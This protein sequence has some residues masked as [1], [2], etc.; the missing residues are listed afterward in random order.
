MKNLSKFYGR[1]GYQ[2]FVDR[3]YRSENYSARPID[4]RI[5]RDWNNSTVIWEP[6][7]DGIFR[8]REFYGGNLRGI[9]E[10]LD[11]L[12]ELGINLIIL[13]PISKTASNHHYD[14]EDQRKID[15]YI[16]TATDFEELC[17]KAH[18]KGMLI[19]NDLVFN[20]F[21][22]QCQYFKEAMQGNPLYYDWIK[23]DEHGNYK[24]WYVFKNMP[25][26]NQFSEGYI[27]YVK[28]VVESYLKRGSDGFRLDLG[29][30]L[31]PYFINKIREH[32]EM[33]N[34][35]C[36]IVNERWEF[37][38]DQEGKYY[39]DLSDTIMNY[40]FADANIRWVRYGNYLHF[41]YTMSR[42]DKYPLS[43]KLLLWNMIDSHDTIRSMTML[44]GKGMEGDPLKNSRQWNIEGPWH[45][46]DG[47]FDTYAFR[48]WEY[49]NDN[50]YSQETV[51]RLII[52]STIQYLVVGN[53]VTFYGT[54]V[55]LSGYKDP[56]NRKPFPWDNMNPMLFEHYKKL[57]QIR[58]DNQAI[59]KT[60]NQ[61]INENA[62]FM[63][64]ERWSD[65]EDKIIAIINR[66][67]ESV[68]I[69]IPVFGHI[70][71]SFGEYDQNTLYGNSF[72][73]CKF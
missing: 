70:L 67:K 4:G 62:D 31:E 16:G 54:E 15:P 57:G 27:E 39:Y 48:K 34:P 10:K 49:E 21:G 18:E 8:N 19:I 38:N 6:E 64:I 59:F 1:T 17:R 68:P 40:P 11:Y 12:E 55:G 41:D 56:F 20:H 53:P 36:L 66:S 51:R 9:I 65:E 3:F 61:D 29:E 33:I 30:N 23:R 37:A 46:L 2:I 69:D 13:T 32:A 5:N 47:T 22:I 50:F 24:Y 28:S 43:V 72:I 7:V 63:K 58:R 60:V 44:G 35:E 14:V 71:Y 52:A 73:I 45:S 42:I 26:A 25:E